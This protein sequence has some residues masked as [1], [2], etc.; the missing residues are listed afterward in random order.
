M[1][2]MALQLADDRPP[3]PPA[4]L[5]LRVAPPFAADD[6][7][8]VREA[9]DLDALTHLRSYERAL[10][11]VGR[12]FD[13]FDRLLDFGCGCGRFVRHFGQLA[14]QVEVHG[15]DID[16]EMID[17]LRANVPYGSYE[18]APHEPPLLYADHYFDLVINHSVF[19]HL[20]ERMQDLWLGELQRIT[21]PGGLLMLTVEGVTSWNR[22][23]KASELAGEDPERW[24]D[25][26]ESRGILFISD[27]L[28]VGSSH[29]DFYHSA[30]HAPWYV[31]EHWT[32]FFDIAA[33]IPNGSLS[34]DLVVFRRRD[35]DAVQPR[36]IG[37]RLQNA[38]FE[39]SAATAANAA[40]QPS[41]ARRAGAGGR[42]IAHR[43]TSALNRVRHSSRTT[44]QRHAA[45]TDPG[46]NGGFPRALASDRLD[47]QALTRE[48]AML[49]VGLYEQGRRIS[50]LAAQLRDEID[51][52][53]N[54]GDDDR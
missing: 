18:V 37:R 34:Q 6:I 43:A 19:S 15:T 45:S 39:A 48:M 47:P 20:D 29:P 5:I 46:A 51:A 9:F 33:Y 30:V 10:A 32:R 12:S 41:A 49:R 53:R 54:A 50:I 16:A 2:T 38:G 28:F 31:F 27:D 1:Q 7:A 24:R 44:T 35:D 17:W 13:E 52:L 3:L 14:G 42:R 4:D 40:A 25:E 8:S 23:A 26:L 11:C 22:T 36:P 21:R